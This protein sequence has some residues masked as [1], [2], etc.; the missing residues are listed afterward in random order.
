MVVL[1][2]RFRIYLK[3]K[4]ENT[5]FESKPAPIPTDEW[6]LLRKEIFRP[7]GFKRYRV[8][9]YENAQIEPEKENTDFVK[10]N[11]DILNTPNRAAF[12]D[13]QQFE[14]Y[15]TESI[16]PYKAVPEESKFFRKEQESANKSAYIPVEHF[17][18]KESPEKRSVG[19]YMPVRHNERRLELPRDSNPYKAVADFVRPKPGGYVAVDDNKRNNRNHPYTRRE[20]NKSSFTRPNQSPYQPV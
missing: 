12:G 20:N 3:M 5:D 18:R 10:A 2:S 14:E 17:E 15:Q 6:N 19:G 7:T 4:R 11:F 9:N 1:Q 8:T 13:H 16:C